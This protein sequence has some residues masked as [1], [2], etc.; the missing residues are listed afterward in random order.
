M[1]LTSPDTI[2]L[3]RQNGRFPFFGVTGLYELYKR[4]DTSMRGSQ[5]RASANKTLRVAETFQSMGNKLQQFI[6]SLHFIQKREK[7][8][9]PDAEGLRKRSMY[10]INARLEFCRNFVLWRRSESRMAQMSHH[11]SPLRNSGLHPGL[12]TMA[13]GIP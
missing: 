13:S 8:I 11:L 10:T 6:K 3:S 5:V 12:P 9:L 7:S 1:K 4:D 2:I